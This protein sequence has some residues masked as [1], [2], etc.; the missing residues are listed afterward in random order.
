MKTP[1]AS[2]LLAALL[3][4]PFALAKTSAPAFHR[5]LAQAPLSPSELIEKTGDKYPVIQLPK[6]YQGEN[7][8]G[9]QG[10][11]ADV[12]YMSPAE[13][14]AIRVVI[15]DGRVHDNQG[16]LYQAP[17]NKLMYVMDQSGN[18]YFF[19]QKGHGELRHSSFFAGGPVAGAGEILVKD[20]LI[21]QINRD[22]GHYD[23]Q[24][25]HLKNVMGELESDGVDVGS[26]ATLLKN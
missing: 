25:K 14:E 1:F 21:T 22:S 10:K 13:R 5:Q 3:C 7:K 2:L 20:S 9:F 17:S 18:F 8:P 23:P 24:P 26:V 6:L 16:A 15:K 12:H 11:H 4:S 19:N